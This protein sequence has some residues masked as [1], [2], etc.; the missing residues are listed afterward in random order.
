[1]LGFNKKKK[2]MLTIEHNTKSPTHVEA[3]TLDLASKL[4]RL[5]EREYQLEEQIKRDNAELDNVREVV[6]A[7]K[8][9]QS[10]LEA[11]QTIDNMPWNQILEGVTEGVQ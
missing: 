3:A 6:K 7:Y 1:M 2:Y 5:S 8:Q 10:M 11:A 9:S 4:A